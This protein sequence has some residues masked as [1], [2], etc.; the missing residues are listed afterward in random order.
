MFTRKLSSSI[1]SMSGIKDDDFVQ[2]LIRALSN[3]TVINKLQNAVCGQL[4][5]EVAQL[6][7]I[8]K[9]KDETINKLEQRVTS[10]EYGLDEME[11]YSRRNSLRISG[12]ME[13]ESEDVVK[14]AME[15][16][17]D[18]MG[19]TVEE[20][21]IDRIHRVGKKTEDATKP[22]Q[23]LVKFATYQVRNKVMRKRSVLKPDQKHTKESAAP[24][25]SRIFINEDLTKMRSNLLYH[26]RQLKKD[27]AILDCWS[28]DGT[29]LVKNS[30]SKIIPV[31]T[32]SDLQKFK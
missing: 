11:Q 9:N 4:Q 30:V 8:I 7:D 18:T 10:L 31:R 15:L 23:I 21:K 17:N 24:P 32:M 13:T 25:H 22:R 6:R 27:K 3:E 2:V 20:D 12:V 26:A 28:W 14:K 16:F 29:I 5:K 19:V 1:L